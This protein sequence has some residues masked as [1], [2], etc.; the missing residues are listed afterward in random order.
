MEGGPSSSSNESVSSLL[1]IRILNSSHIDLTTLGSACGRLAVELG[2][3]FKV[4]V[5]DEVRIVS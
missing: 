1:E 4:V 3:K 2:N 5:I